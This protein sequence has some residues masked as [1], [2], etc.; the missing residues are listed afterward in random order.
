MHIFLIGER[1]IGKSLAIRNAVKL[2]RRTPYGFLTLFQDGDPDSSSLCMVP[3]SHPDWTDNAH[4]I[5]LRKDGR[6]RLLPDR[7]ESLATSLLQEARSHPEGIILMDEC[8]HLEAGLD[9]FHREVLQCLDGNI[10]VL[11]ALRMD[12][13]WHAFIKNHPGVRVLPVTMDNRDSLPEKIAKALLQPSLTD[14]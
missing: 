11:G 13:S 5:A 10:P 7:F 4:R 12:Q 14:H 9:C 8:G 2:L 1:G 3:P 6:M